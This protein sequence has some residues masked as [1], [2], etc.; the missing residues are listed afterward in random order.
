[1]L[2]AAG[3]RN[4]VVFNL[5]DI[6]RTPA[7]TASGQPAQISAITGFF[8]TTLFGGLDT[9]GAPTMRVNAFALFNEI[10][11]NPGA[12]GFVNVTTPAC[13]TTGSLVCTSANFV[14][15]DAATTF[16]F[17]DGVHP[18]TAGHA[19][20]AE[21]VASMIEGPAQVGVLAEAPLAVERATFRA[22]D[23]RMISG[24]N[25]PRGTNKFD[26]WASYDYG[27]NDF[28]GRLLNG[29]A[30]VNTIA[31]GG[32]I[33]VTPNILV[34]AAVTFAQN[35][36]DFGG[37]NGGYKLDETA[38]TVY[39][40]YGSGPWY[41][42]I[43]LGGGDLDYHDVHRDIRLGTATRRESGDTRGWHVMGSLLGGYW[44]DYVDWLHGPFARVS[45]QEIRVRGYSENGSDSTAL[46]YGEQERES[47]I[48]SLGWQVSGRIASVRPFARIAWEFESKD[49]QRYV[50]ASSVTLGGSY[51]VPTIKPDRDY[52]SYLVG[53]AADFGSVT[54]YLTGSATSGR[55]SGDEYG[56]TLGV[57]V[58]F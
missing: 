13:G 19:I 37:G 55:G 24:M 1:V 34:G 4:I 5:P 23:G 15:P 20:I 9:L 33:K 54:G 17:A 49:D 42:G 12:Y 14:V 44:F 26:F 35:K 52:V 32:D 56:V 3:A 11:A 41:A 30:D 22:I 38:G 43:T 58:P 57:R 31:A 18:T 27:N 53:A 28:D 51:S 8:N 36:G 6:G 47:L 7:G 21:V 29:D 25:A 45:Y 48:T 50:S 40:G 10:L 2:Q 39:A 16:A 46:S